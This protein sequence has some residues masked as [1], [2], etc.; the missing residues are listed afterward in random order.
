VTAS[1]PSASAIAA[2]ASTTRSVSSPAR[3]IG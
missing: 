2:A 3:G 1:R